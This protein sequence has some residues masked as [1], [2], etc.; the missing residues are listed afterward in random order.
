M[1]RHL[2]DVVADVHSSTWFTIQGLVDPV[3]TELGTRAG[4]PL[5]DVCY[6]FIVIRAHNHIEIELKNADLITCLPPLRMP[7]AS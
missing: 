3:C 5:A 4:D 2:N 7:F 1:N 6:N